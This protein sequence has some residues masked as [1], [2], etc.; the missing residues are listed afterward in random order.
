MSMKFLDSLLGK[1][2][3]TE[4]IEELKD[5]ICFLEREI[6]VKESVIQDLYGNNEKLKDEKKLLNNMLRKQGKELKKI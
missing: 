6:K 3:L 5:K 4:E 1:T 2:K